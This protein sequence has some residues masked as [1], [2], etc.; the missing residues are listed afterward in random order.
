MPG[1][2]EDADATLHLACTWETAVATNLSLDMA[3]DMESSLVGSS[4]DL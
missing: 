3:G 4:T 2:I 1:F